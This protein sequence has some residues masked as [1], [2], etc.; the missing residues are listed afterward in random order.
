MVKNEKGKNPY[1]GTWD[2]LLK[3]VRREGITGLWVGYP[4]FYCRVA[5]HAMVSLLVL[6]YLHVHFV[7]NK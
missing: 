5:P 2:C 4:T 7:H 1:R 6:D 3:S